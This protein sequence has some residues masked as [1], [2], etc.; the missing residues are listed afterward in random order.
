MYTIGVDVGG[1]NIRAGIFDG[2]VLLGYAHTP[3][4]AG[5]GADAVLEG[6]FS[7]I[8]NALMFTGTDIGEC[9]GI[10]V[11]CPGLCDRENG[12]V[13][14]A[15][16]LGWT[17]FELSRP[18]SERYG[19]PC[20]IA[21]DADCAALAE[22]AAGAGRGAD[23]LLM[24]T[25]GT[26]VGSGYIVD[27]RIMDGTRSL[28]GELGHVCICMDGEM[29]SCGERGC[30]EAYASAAALMRQARR[31]AEKCPD[32]ALARVEN[33]DAAAVFGLAAEGDAA[34]RGVVE[35]YCRYVAVGVTGAVNL[36]Y[37]EVVVLGGGVARSGEAL[38]GPV[39]EYVRRHA[40]ASGVG[41][42]PKIVTSVLGGSAGMLGAALL[43]AGQDAERALL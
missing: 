8:E 31:A 20:R 36:L 5:M 32:S 35:R 30:L 39:R 12:V 18:V 1:T 2:T 22:Y 40:F 23:S 3:T 16:N 6:V 29:C 10:G 33:P 21:N 17:R 4:R 41:E 43:M 25:L 27:G 28:G 26:G 34:A 38:A 15:H 42:M 24:I 14:N 11:G 13:L 19:L 9:A 37:P 7:C